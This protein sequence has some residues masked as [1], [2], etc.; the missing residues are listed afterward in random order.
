MSEWSVSRVCGR[1][2]HSSNGA[3]PRVVPGYTNTE[4]QARTKKMSWNHKQS[5]RVQ[6]SVP[7]FHAGVEVWICRPNV[8]DKKVLGAVV[9]LEGKLSSC[10]STGVTSGDVTVREL[11]ERWGEET[12]SSTG[13]GRVRFVVRTLLPRRKQLQQSYDL[14]ISG[15]VRLIICQPSQHSRTPSMVNSL[16]YGHVC[17]L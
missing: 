2:D 4:S 9:Q 16:N 11:R 12:A 10:W 14:V 3:H 15:M 5:V 1:I 8:V 7:G 13:Y 17:L 6:C